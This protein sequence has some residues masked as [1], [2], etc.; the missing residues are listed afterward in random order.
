MS[1]EE[2]KLQRTYRKGQCVGTDHVE[3]G[4]IV[5]ENQNVSLVS[6]SVLV[7]KGSETNVQIENVWCK[8]LIDTGSMV[9]TVSK[10]F[11][12]DHLFHIPMLPIT[13]ELC[14]RTATGHQLS[15][16]GFIEVDLKFVLEK[17]G[18][19][20]KVA[21]M[22]V[23]P[24]T[25]YTSRVPLLV[26]TNVLDSFSQGLVKPY[27][28][29]SSSAVQVVPANGSVIVQGELSSS[30]EVSCQLL[31][32]DTVMENTLPGDVRVLP[33]IPRLEKESGK[34]GR[35]VCQVEVQNLSGREKI[36]PANTVIC[37][38]QDVTLASEEDVV[39]VDRDK[40]APDVGKSQFLDL[41]DLSQSVVSPE[42]REKLE[43]FL[44]QWKDVFSLSEFDLGHT[45]LVQHRIELVEDTPVK[46]RY[47]RIP[48]MLYGE[49]RQHLD[50]MLK[51]G[52]IQ[53]SSSAWSSPVVLVR[54]K[55]GSLRFCVDY[56]KLNEN[57]KKDAYY[58]PRIEE[59]LDALCGAKYFSCLDLKMGYWQVSV[60][61][62]HRERTAFTVGPLGFF[63]FSSLPYG[64][65]NSPATF[66]RLMEQCLSGLHLDQCLVYLDDVVV[67]SSSMEEHLERLGTVFQRFRDHGLKLKPSKCQFLRE[68]ISYLGHLVSEH[69]V[70][71]DPGKVAA[72]QNLSP[73]KNV[74]E[75]QRFLG[76]VGFFRRFIEN[77]SSLVN[78][79]TCLLK[80]QNTRRKGRKRSQSDSFVWGEGQQ[81]C[82]E[83]LKKVVTQTPILAF[84][85]FRKPF[86]LHCDA[87]MTGL[88]AVLYQKQDDGSLRVI[89]YASRSLTKSEKNYAVHKLEFLALK[90]SITEKFHEYL[91]GS[92]FCVRTDNNPLTYVFTSA[93]LDATGQRWVAALSQYDFSLSYCPGRQNV[94]AD[95]LSRHPVVESS[96]E[97]VKAILD[98]SDPEGYVNALCCSQEAVEVFDQADSISNIPRLDIAREQRQDVV[99]KRVI[100]LLVAG[101]KPSK[102]DI[103]KE[104]L[105]VIK[106]VHQWD[107]LSM[108]QEVLCREVK[109]K[110][111]ESKFQVVVPTHL[112]ERVFQSLHEEMGHGGRDRTLSLVLDRFY[113]PGV[114]SDIEKQ[115]AGC[116]R[117]ICRKSVSQQAPLVPMVSTYPMELV[118][119]DFLTVEPSKGYENILVLTDHFTKYAQAF[120]T[121]NQSAKTTARILYEHFVVHYGI[122]SKLHS[123][124]GRNFEGRIVKELCAL[125]GTKK[126]RTSAYH[127]MGNG[128]CERMNRSLLAMLGTLENSQ[129]RKWKD[130]L[131]SV[132]HAY[133][134]TKHA[135][136]GYSPYYLMFGRDPQLPVDIEFS[137][138]QLN[139]CTGR[140][141]YCEYVQ[142]LK[143]K[144]SKSWQIAQKSQ[145]VKSDKQKQLYDVRQKGVVLKKGDVVL[146]RKLGV[147][148][149]HKLA[150][151]W[152]E[153]PWVVDSQPN[154]QVPVYK[155]V[156]TVKGKRKNRIL[157]RNHLLPTGQF[158]ELNVTVDKHVVHKAGRRDVPDSSSESESESD[159]EIV[160]IEVPS[161]NN[162]VHDDA[163]VLYESENESDN[164]LDVSDAHESDVHESD[165]HESDVHE[166]D[167][168]ESDVSEVEVPEVEEEEVIE[169]VVP[170]VPAPRRSCRRA[171]S[172]DRFGEWVNMYQTPEPTM[173]VSC[174]EWLRKTKFLMEMVDRYPYLSKQPN[175]LQ[176]VVELVKSG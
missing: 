35:V 15:Y 72:V 150:D 61:E 40:V 22:L 13:S 134:C 133:N 58:L 20:S 106:L 151:K 123:D 115:V 76:F 144:L 14:I 149:R 174:P 24:D 36:I 129:K 105:N 78:P 47:R 44:L 104:C 121:K 90:W 125:L 56:R 165:V 89:G 153:E 30:S 132:V 119:V 164:D 103:S 171:K 62:A 155:I 127:A 19:T 77:Y 102:K 158:K 79:L 168:H 141:S 120:P 31:L 42:D 101:R 80:G 138:D 86:L 166:S 118:C 17:D 5:D 99:V 95:M 167:A 65:C 128:L 110:D 63:E 1:L 34:S 176:A 27:E 81:E 7:G 39:L 146:V 53:P 87:S 75:L 48:P 54:K 28:L 156:P 21:S 82:F 74:T 100:D 140:G 25:D 38:L 108:Q 96:V 12:D 33:G 59:T 137:V 51:C 16:L 142:N 26:G 147:K 139:D 161:V 46:Q 37:G 32:A 122:P 85:D 68:K 175:L 2:G 60:D 113:W 152:E 169:R 172:P 64:L 117:C 92:K 69:G 124:Q 160:L 111:E 29:L 162:A 45:D 159:N 55:D 8:A 4:P 143:D 83:K 50:E 73:P 66:Q 10:G 157:H 3:S 93:K 126:T 116:K 136:T 67:F 112:R 97:V 145:Q 107:K 154:G 41:F 114:S 173:S 130:F 94:Q 91:Y 170:P 98:R 11:Y 23:V 57:T 84:A 6:Q 49:V 18:G 88:G 43:D 70:E 9:S 52:V 148:G 109:N 131:S 71:V 135:S 163:N